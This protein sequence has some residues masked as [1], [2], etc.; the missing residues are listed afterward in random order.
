MTVAALTVSAEATDAEVFVIGVTPGKGDEPPT[1]LWDAPVLAGSLQELGV[2]AGKDELTRLPASA[3]GEG[4][5]PIGSA[6]V[7]A[8]VGLGGAVSIETLRYAAG[9]A[10]RQLTGKDRIALGLPVADEA[11]ALAV[12]EGAAVGA[13]VFDTYKHTS[14]SPTRRVASSIE[15]VTAAAV[16]AATVEKAA[17]VATA[18]HTVRDLVA[19]PPIDLPPAALADE[20]VR[21]AAESPS[22]DL[23][24]TVLA[25]DELRDA[26][27][28]GIVGVG[29]GSARPPRLVKV[30]YSPAGAAK[31]LALVGKGITYDTGGLSLKPAGAMLGMKYDMTGAATVLAVTIAA[32]RLA[33]PVRLTAWLCIS[34]NMLGADPIRPDDVLTIKNGTT[35]EVT[36]TDAE[37]RL[38]LADG[39]SAASEEQPD[40]IVD[41]ATLTGAQVVALGMRYVGVMGTD[42]FA[43][44]VV[45]VADGASEPF[46]RVP[47][48][49]EL[50]ARLN[51]DVADLVN[52]TPGNTAAGMLLA[53]VFLKE[54]VGKRE[55]T[56]EL[57]PWAHLDIAG[58]SE[59]K[60]GGYGFTTKGAT[61]I[62]VRT[63]I[64]LAVS[65]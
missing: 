50:R 29:Q 14:A 1:L 27:F 16:D 65:F 17:A 60:A 31:H 7:V 39:I 22:G 55:G 56:D 33:L 62:A 51:S 61:G 57:I 38:V 13:Y 4:A 46:W 64:D 43:P 19:T 59:N 25:G 26:G 36:N 44:R 12:L 20:A 30:A 47:L 54:F 6:P 48:A 34:E 15:L 35:V 42:D 24:V 11:E 49:P 18:V 10:A 28:G 45:E 2:V 9:S 5:A 53:G 8:L 37:G 32:A 58:P 52:A 63:L 41:V 23:T 21:L 3:L 40:A